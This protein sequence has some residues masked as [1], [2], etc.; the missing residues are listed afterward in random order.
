MSDKKHFPA[1]PNTKNILEGGEG[2]TRR[3]YFAAL[4]MQGI[5]ASGMR[6]HDPDLKSHMADSRMVAIMALNDADALL[7]ELEK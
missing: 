3:E 1:F 4:A 6:H 2:L 5:R 7:A